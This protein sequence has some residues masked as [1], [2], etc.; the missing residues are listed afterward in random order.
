MAV[1]ANIDFW[2]SLEISYTSGAIYWLSIDL[3]IGPYAWLARFRAA[4]SKRL[5]QVSCLR[6]SE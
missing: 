6:L 2:Y 1:K 4:S 3:I 5:D